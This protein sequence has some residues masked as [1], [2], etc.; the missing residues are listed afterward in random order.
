[1]KL[2]RIYK[3]QIC[4][5][6]ALHHQKRKKKEKKENKKKKIK[7]RSLRNQKNL[8]RNLQMIVILKRN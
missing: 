1:M 3:K 8:L 6:R 4:L 2:V 5:I 7:K